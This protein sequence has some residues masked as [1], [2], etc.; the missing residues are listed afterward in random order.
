MLGSD[1]SLDK[2][3]CTDGQHQDQSG[4]TKSQLRTALARAGRIEAKVHTR[5][6]P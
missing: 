5:S 4:E 2:G 1:V 3:I 6:V